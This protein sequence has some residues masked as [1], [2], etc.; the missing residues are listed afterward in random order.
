MQLAVR[1]RQAKIAGASMHTEGALFAD[2][3]SFPFQLEPIGQLGQ[4]GEPGKLI[5]SYSSMKAFYDCPLKYYFQFH[6]RYWRLVMHR[7]ASSP[8][9]ILGQVMHDAVETVS[10]LKREGVDVGSTTL[11]VTVGGKKEKDEPQGAAPVKEEGQKESSGLDEKESTGLEDMTLGQLLGELED[12]DVIE[13]EGPEAACPT[14]G[15]ATKQ[16]TTKIRLAPEQSLKKPRQARQQERET[17]GAQEKPEVPE[18]EKKEKR[19]K[20]KEQADEQ[21]QE[22]SEDRQEK[23]EPT[24]AEPVARQAQ[25]EPE[26]QQEKAKSTKWQAKAAPAERQTKAEAKAEPTKRQAKAEMMADPAARQAKTETRR[27]PE[28]IDSLSTE[29]R[30]VVLAGIEAAKQGDMRHEALVNMTVDQ[31]TQ[32][33]GIVIEK[34]MWKEEVLWRT[35]QQTLATK[36]KEGRSRKAKAELHHR[37]AAMLSRIAQEETGA[38]KVDSEVNLRATVGGALLAGKID[39]IL[40]LKEGPIIREYKLTALGLRNGVEQMHIYLFLYELVSGVRPLYGIVE[41]L[42]TGEQ[43]RV[44]PSDQAN[45][46]VSALIASTE[47]AIRTESF[48]AT[49]S[50]FGCARCP[51]R[52]QCPKSPYTA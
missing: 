17:A 33:V 19:M 50:S 34:G 49:P 40:H 46:Q 38:I 42:E 2:G 1:K 28:A 32:A 26:E 9:A 37:T 29:D 10:N 15:I 39:Q 30:P 21:P 3:F 12:D 43:V 6:N 48:L 11:G 7:Q 51:L 24:K 27:Q 5:I 22:E 45:E 23:A 47:K 4:N 13:P 52:G 18:R 20:P 25:P 14:L 44:L 31:L 8:K 16:S 41:V 35:L 36:M